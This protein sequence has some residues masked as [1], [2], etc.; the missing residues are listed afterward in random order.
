MYTIKYKKDGSFWWAE[1][2]PE[3][4]SE[5]FL[6]ET[7]K[8]LFELEFFCKMFWGKS[9][10]LE[11]KIA[12]ATQIFNERYLELDKQIL[13]NLLDELNSKGTKETNRI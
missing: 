3:D 7:A 11:S 8:E 12:K 6:H 10:P 1:Y 2:I 4:P 13:Q 5:K 9:P